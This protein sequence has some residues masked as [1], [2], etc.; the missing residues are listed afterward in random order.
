MPAAIDIV[1]ASKSKTGQHQLVISRVLLTLELTDRW[2][3]LHIVK[4]LL[5]IQSDP[6]PLALMVS[7][8]DPSLL[9]QSPA[10]CSALSAVLPKTQHKVRL[11]RDERPCLH[12]VVAGMVFTVTN[13]RSCDVW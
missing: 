6:L 3:F 4:H 13:R 11:S 5:R 9:K 7:R 2:C 1:S 10:L 12:I 8:V